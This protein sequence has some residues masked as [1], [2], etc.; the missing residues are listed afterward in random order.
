MAKSISVKRKKGRPATGTEPLYGVR[1]SDVLMKQIMDWAKT[2]G[3]TRSEA[4]RRLVELGLAAPRHSDRTRRPGRSLD[5]GA[6]AK[7]EA[8]PAKTGRLTR[9]RE[10]AAEVIDKMG[11]PT[12]HPDE[13]AQRRQRLTKGPPEF[14]EVRV[15][16]PKA[17]TK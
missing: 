16:R 10:L 17:K 2:E 11:D 9:A 5:L 15:D 7:L 1:I 4:I 6:M 13:R 3:A 14:R 8:A 12:A